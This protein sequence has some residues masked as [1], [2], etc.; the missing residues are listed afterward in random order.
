MNN[1][2]FFSLLNKYNTNMN[3]IEETNICLI[4]HE[5]LTENHIELECGHMFNYKNIF[6][7]VKTQKNNPSYYEV[8]KLRNNEIK[9]PYCRRKQN[10]ILPHITGYDKIKYVNTPIYMVM[11]LNKCKHRYKSGKRKGQLC[12]KKC[13][14]EYCTRCGRYAKKSLIKATLKNSTLKNVEVCPVILKS[15]KRKGQPC[16]VSCKVNGKCGRHKHIID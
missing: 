6:N 8:Q 11:K 14:K 3:E 10:G 5:S 2:I 4:S 9:C 16:N 7:E 15:G 1:N 12:N 13:T